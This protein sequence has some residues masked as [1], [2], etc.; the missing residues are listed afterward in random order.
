MSWDAS[1][2]KIM[3]Q[4]VIQPG[5]HHPN[6]KT[7]QSYSLNQWHFVA[8]NW[9]LDSDVMEIYVDG[10]FDSSLSIPDGSIG[11]GN[12]GANSGWKIGGT[13]NGG[14]YIGKMDD[15]RIYRRTLSASE[16]QVLFQLGPCGSDCFT[17][18]DIDAAYQAG[19]NAGL[20]ASSSGTVGGCATYDLFTNK[21]H[22]PCL[23]LGATYW[24]DLTVTGANPLLFELTD[25]G[26]N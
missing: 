20:A 11:L 14:D 23:D 18:A 8:A 15:I 4:A 10:Q 25:F 13:W 21:L 9:N 26:A 12:G 1:D 24:L 3:M 22:I 16:I 19:Y 7:R 6:F 17:Q 5:D 2:N